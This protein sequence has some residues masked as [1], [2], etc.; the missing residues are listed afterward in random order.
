MRAAH[1]PPLERHEGWKEIFSA[2]AR[3]EL[4]GRQHAFDPLSLPRARFAETEGFELLTRLQDVDLGGYLVDDLLVKTDRA[5]MAWVAES[6]GSSVAWLAGSA[7][8]EA[9]FGRVR[10]VAVPS[11]EVLYDTAGH[12]SYSE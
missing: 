4:T 6:R 12:D 5:S 3:T 1:L 11:R 8:A 9:D 7:D 2:D 10:I